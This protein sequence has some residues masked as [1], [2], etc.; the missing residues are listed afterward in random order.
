[1]DP[2]VV[3]AVAHIA[4]GAGK[5]FSHS[6][7]VVGQRNNNIIRL[8]QFYQK[9]AYRA[10]KEYEAIQAKSAYFEGT[11]YSSFDGQ[12]LEVDLR[13]QT[14]KAKL[15]LSVGGVELDCTCNSVTVENLRDALNQKVTV[16]ALAHYDGKSRLPEHLTIKKI[17]I[18]GADRSLDR[19]MGKFDLDYPDAE[20]IW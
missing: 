17:N 7:V 12:L 5:S 1:M 2:R 19:W 16:F 3:R 11:V 6:E 4:D 8:D 9:K 18:I 14:A 20:D 10:L 13:G 15:V